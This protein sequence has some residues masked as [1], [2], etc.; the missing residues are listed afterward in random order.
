MIIAV[1]YTYDPAAPLAEI[2][3]SHREYLAGLAAD[4]V[5]VSS[6]PLPESNGALLIVSADSPEAALS[7]LEGDPFFQARCIATRTAEE[8]RPVIGVLAP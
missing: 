5:I 6:G 8:W 1:R 2:R 7:I 3:P 4:G